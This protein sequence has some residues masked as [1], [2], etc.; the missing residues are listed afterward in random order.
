[1]KIQYFVVSALASLL[2]ACGGSNTKDVPQGVQVGSTLVSADI[3]KLGN[4]S[5]NTESNYDAQFNTQTMASATFDS[6]KTPVPPRAL[7]LLTIINTPPGGAKCNTYILDEEI[8]FGED[9]A[10]I[11]EL[12]SM[13]YPEATEISAGD[14]I[15]ITTPSGIW[16][17]LVREPI[18]Y[19][20][21]QTGREEYKT[22]TIDMGSS[23][24][25]PGA[26]FPAMSVEMLPTA[27]AF[28]NL[29]TSANPITTMAAGATIT[30]QA[31]TTS[32]ERYVTIRITIGESAATGNN[33]SSFTKKSLLECFTLDNGQFEV[34]AQLTQ[35]IATTGHTVGNIMLLREA[36]D[37]KQ[38][39]DALLL[40]TA[41][42]EAYIVD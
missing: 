33:G 7:E 42:S 21:Y 3:R 41:K 39:G 14:S 28:K 31:A 23:I 30:W 8:S 40:M 35:L 29:A 34:P 10:A 37:S 24:N 19:S 16:P 6:Y 5:L 9:M 4:I 25:I 2:S 13:D 17:E 22:G 15:I 38:E 32:K 11:S 1:M 18:A 12:V 36:F 26:E 27:E 20:G